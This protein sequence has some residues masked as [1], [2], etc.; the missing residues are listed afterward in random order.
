MTAMEL[1]RI[2]L[3]LL[4]SEPFKATLGSVQIIYPNARIRKGYVME[5]WCYC[6]DSSH[7]QSLGQLAALLKHGCIIHE[8]AP[9]G[10]SLYNLRKILRRQS[11]E[12]LTL[13]AA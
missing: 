7:Q 11:G 12:S 10:N 3:L 9:D 4:L 6:E 5:L 1:L 13:A 2:E 8:T